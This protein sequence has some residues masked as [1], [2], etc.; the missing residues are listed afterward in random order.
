MKMNK[1]KKIQEEVEKTLHSL[2][3]IEDIDANPFLYTRLMAE[4]SERQEGT[5]KPK[6]NLVG[7]KLLRPVFFVILF[8]VNLVSIIYVF[9]SGESQINYRDDYLSAFAEEYSLDNPN[10]EFLELSE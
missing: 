9:Q 10:D 2:D 4:I 1:G 5:L 3:N 6:S 7:I 8:L